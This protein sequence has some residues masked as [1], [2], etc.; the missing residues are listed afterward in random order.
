M[1]R[2]LFS[3]LRVVAELVILAVLL[4]LSYDPLL[5]LTNELRDAYFPCS[6][7]V[8]YRLDIFDKRFGLTRE[9]FLSIAAEAEQVWEKPAGRQLLAYAADGKLRL[10]LIYDYRQE[11]TDKLAKMGL[12]ITTDRASYDTLKAKYEQIFADFRRQKAEYVA[13]VADFEARQKAYEQEVASWNSRGG[14]PPKEF[15][16]LSG[17]RA[18]L[19][20]EV[21]QLKTL[22]AA[23]NE[24]ADQVN[25]AVTVLNRLI[26]ELNLAADKFNTVVQDRGQEFQQGT[27]RDSTAGNEIDIYEFENRRQLLRVLAHEFGHALGLEHVDDPNAI[28]NMR[29]T[30]TG[31]TATA[32][33]IQALKARCRIH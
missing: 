29:N 33:D 14:A 31:V 6:R 11:A 4:Y 27:Y 28:M 9:E 18:A 30:G 15:D 1:D 7:P 24:R 23:V 12:T 20:A 13:R 16:R 21:E 8:T 2:K 3:R 17:V 19:Q 10:N 26:N 5:K 22:A 25:A 32:S